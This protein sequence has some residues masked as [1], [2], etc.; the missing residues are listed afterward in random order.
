MALLAQNCAQRNTAS[1]TCS[2][3]RHAYRD[4]RDVTGIPESETDVC[5]SPMDKVSLLRRDTL[6]RSRAREG[7]L[8]GVAFLLMAHAVRLAALRRTE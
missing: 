4:Q 2:R 5:L 1:L 3:H 7:D 6:G 8:A